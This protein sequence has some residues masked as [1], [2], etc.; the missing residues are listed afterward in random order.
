[1]ATIIP[2]NP[3]SPMAVVNYYVDGSGNVIQQGANTANYVITTAS[4]TTTAKATSGIYYG[5]TVVTAGTNSTMAVLDGAAQF[6]PTTT[7]TAVGG[8]SLG[9]PAAGARTVNNILIVS[10]GTAVSTTAHFYA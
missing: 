3:S 2:G 7:N 5:S 6:V 1:M 4:G 8:V 10:T 9:V